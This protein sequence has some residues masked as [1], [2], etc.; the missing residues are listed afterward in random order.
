MIDRDA[1][2]QMAE[3]LRH[4]AAGQIINCDWDEAAWQLAKS[5]DP[6]LH[7]VFVAVWG[8]YD[9][10][11]EHTLSGKDA[12]TEKTRR[13][14]ARCVLFLQS[15][16]EYPL[17]R[18]RASWEKVKFALWPVQWFFHG[19]H[20]LLAAI[21]IWPEKDTGRD[22]REWWPFSNQTEYEEALKH[23]KLLCG[24]RYR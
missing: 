8:L 1:R 12:L 3:L 2:N 6:A 20:K 13:N 14:V 5:N 22:Y 24:N 7:A 15:D 19:L 4:F 9:D 17:S 16:V 21:R 11:R 18:L 23:P 10:L